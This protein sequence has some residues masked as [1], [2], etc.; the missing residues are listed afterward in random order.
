MRR[1]AGQLMMRAALLIFAGVILGWLVPEIASARLLF[2]DDFSSGDLS[3]R[4][5]H[6]RWGG[7]ELLFTGEGQDTIDK[8][9]GPDGRRVNAR[10]FR[11]GTWQEQ[12]FH[13]TASADEPR[14]PN[15]RS[16][17]AHQEIWVSYWMRVPANYQHSGSGG[18]AGH[19]N[20]GWLYLWKDAYEQWHSRWKDDSTVT[21]TSLSLHWWPT[22]QAPGRS[23]VRIASTRYRSD[24]RMRE[25]STCAPE[26]RI[27]SSGCSAFLPSEQGQWIRYTFGMR[28]ASSETAADGFVRVY[29]NGK[30]IMA[31]ERLTGGGTGRQN[32]FDRGYIM[33]YHNSGYREATTFYVTDFKIGTTAAS[34]GIAESGRNRPQAPV[35]FGE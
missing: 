17:V 5:A 26:R 34:V 6:F 10:R 25:M 3:K 31:N 19:N 7:G 14:T 2:E 1:E 22:S 29:A 15:G 8:V 4:N 9:S 18:Q 28:A 23:L 13:L 16:N 11:Y 27:G 33:G 24:W 32:G 12:R 21:P 30:L 20:K 35:L